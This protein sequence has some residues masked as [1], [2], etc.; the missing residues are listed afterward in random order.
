MPRMQLFSSIYF[1]SKFVSC[2]LKQSYITFTG[3]TIQCQIMYDKLNLS[4]ICKHC[5]VNQE[6]GVN[7]T[8]FN[9]QFE[10]F[11]IYSILM[12]DISRLPE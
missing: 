4:A 7:T 10:N 8:C 9:Y 5:E 6:T 2:T 3:N 11:N 1:V 12:Q